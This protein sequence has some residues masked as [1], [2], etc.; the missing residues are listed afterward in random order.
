MKI[1]KMNKNI[2]KNWTYFLILTVLLVLNSCSNFLSFEENETKK[3]AVQNDKC[4]ITVSSDFSESEG[5]FSRAAFPNFVLS[6]ETLYFA[7]ISYAS[8][9]SKKWLGEDSV[10]E[11]AVAIKNNYSDEIRFVFLYSPGNC[12][13]HIYTLRLPKSNRKPNFR[14]KRFCICSRHYNG[15]AFCWS[16]IFIF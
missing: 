14:C 10:C 1:K 9:S 6:S 4:T 13:I 7:E 12:F 2:E 11:T 8:S 15:Y 16:K 5:L 3:T